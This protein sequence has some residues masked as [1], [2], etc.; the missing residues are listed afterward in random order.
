MLK[1]CDR[2]LVFPLFTWVFC[3]LMFISHFWTSSAG[4]YQAKKCKNMHPT[5]SSYQWDI[6]YIYI[7]PMTDP[8]M[9]YMILYDDM[10]PINIPQML[11]YIYI[12]AIHG[13]YGCIYIYIHIC[14]C[15]CL[16]LSKRPT[17]N[18]T[19]YNSS[20][21]HIWLVVSN[22]LFSIIYGI[23]LP[24][25]RAYFSEGLKPP[26]RYVF[27]L[28]LHATGHRCDL[29]QSRHHPGDLGG[30]PTAPRSFPH[31]SREEWYELWGYSL[32]FNSKNRPSL[33]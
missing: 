30:D 8:C 25:W 19:I 17:T 28:S 9:L 5:S 13:S 22:I 2:W 24:N 31:C 16:I 18:T 3:A 29:A 11:A 6:L 32:K 27:Q 33:W 7:S 4:G 15:V 1:P 14:L 20:P 26:T 21:K 23:I 10:D 12:Y